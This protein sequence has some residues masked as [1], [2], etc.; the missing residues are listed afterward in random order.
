[1]IADGDPHLGT[2]SLP[3]VLDSN[4]HPAVV[5]AVLYGVGDEILESRSKCGGIANNRRRIG[6][7]VALDRDVFR[8]EK[9]Q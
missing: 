7:E 9:R 4:A 5:A 3:P 1:M 6:N 8:S 2:A